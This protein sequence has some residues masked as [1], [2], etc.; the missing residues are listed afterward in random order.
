MPESVSVSVPGHLHVLVPVTPNDVRYGKNRGIIPI[1]FENLFKHI[2]TNDDPNVKFQ[3]TF[4]MLEVYM[5]QV[6]DLLSTA[7]RRKGG[8][9]VREDTKK[10]LFYVEN[11]SKVCA[12]LQGS[13]GSYLR[14]M[15]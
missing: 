6:T 15:R 14:L 7:P 11:L 5:E 8:M 1:A 12:A 10:G 2:D 13:S 4:S 9:K 3:V